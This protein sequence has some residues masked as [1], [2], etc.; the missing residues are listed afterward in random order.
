MKNTQMLLGDE[1]IA[2]AAIHSGMSAAYSYPGTPSTEI[3][4]TIQ[5]EVKNDPDLDVICAW[6]INEKVAMEEGCGASMIG[7]R[8]LITMKHVGLNVAADPFMNMAMT[9][10]SGGLVICVADD[11]SMHSSQNEQDSR[12]FSE[13]AKILCLEPVD[14]QECYDMTMQAFELSEQFKTPVMIRLTTRVAHSRTGVILSENKQDKKSISLPTDFKNWTL[15]PCNARPQYVALLEK[16]KDLQV[17]ANTY[18]LNEINIVP[19]AQKG[20]VVG[21][22]AYPYFK[23][24]LS[25]LK[26]SHVRV[27]TYPIPDEK[28]KK[29]INAVDELYVIEEGYPLIE[30]Q[31]YRLIHETGKTLTIHGR[32][33][34]TFPMA[35]ELTP[36]VVRKGFGLT[37]NEEGV[38]PLSS[39]VKG[40]PPQLCKGC[41]HADTYNALNEV[42]KDHEQ[43]RLVFSD[44]GCYTLGAYP[45]YEA[46]HSC[47]CMGASVSMAKAAGENGLKYS[48][49]VLGDSTFEHSGITPLLEGVSKKV[50][51]TVIILDNARIAMTGGQERI[52]SEEQ[53]IP[54]ILGTGIDEKH[55]RLIKPIPKNHEENVQ[56]IKEECEYPGPSVIVARRV[57]IQK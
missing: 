19:G 46:I 32:N 17:Y 1:A 29:L 13:F 21:G 11:P 3:V 10:T 54:F 12:F 9:G 6:S 23:E 53:F 51:F 4:E 43:E 18:E 42:L 31:L 37:I 5:R 28:I 55:V 25:E 44:I 38:Y 47:V 39:L 8:A 34:G 36:D 52:M 30:N 35:G 2:L 14:S 40:R 26:A 24:C 57:C 16:Q 50:P 48:V 20:V 49:A 27:C 7:K 22:L 15:L 33:D 56:V 45:P 41:P